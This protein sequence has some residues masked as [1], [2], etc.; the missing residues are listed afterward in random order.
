[1][2]GTRKKT[3]TEPEKRV[4]TVTQTAVVTQDH[5][6]QQAM[7]VQ[8]TEDY[9]ED[10]GAGME[11]VRPDETLVPFVRIIQA[12]SPQC[13]ELDPAYDERAK[14]GL[15]HHTALNEYFKSMGFIACHRE[16]IYSEWVPRAK[17]GAQSTASG[18]NG[19]RGIWEAEDPKVVQLVKQHGEYKKLPLPETGTELIE[20][21]SLY[22]VFVPLA[23][24]GTWLV[25]EATNGIL[26]TTSTQI[27][28]YKKFVTDMTRYI[29][30][31]QVQT[32]VGLQWKAM[33]PMFALRFIIK[34]RP[35]SKGG[36]NWYGW[37]IRLANE[38]PSV[39]RMPKTDP[40]YMMARDLHHMIR[41]GEVKADFS[42]SGA[43][44]D[45]A[46]ND[47]GGGQTADG[48]DVPF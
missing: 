5:P 31:H 38:D 2:S 29:G 27:K 10:A 24:D 13:A 1:M 20:T 28:H 16:H 21:R 25:N 7:T 12:G 32:P 18:G 37:D 47:G 3:A 43:A 19:F 42:Q 30:R 44:T 45:T 35:E 6:S 39:Y 40:L 11:N 23:E 15:I 9:G 22:G 36:Y 17:D 46:S 14:K 41:A 34:T 26:A 33:Y 4:E 8:E 48:E